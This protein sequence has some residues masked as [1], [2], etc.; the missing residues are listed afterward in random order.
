MRITLLQYTPDPEKLIEYSARVCYLSHEKITPTSH[1]KFLPGLLKNGHL[2][3]FEHASASFFIEGISRAC[4]HQ[5]V[6]HRLASFSQQSQRYVEES[7]FAYVT[8]PEIA[9][10]PESKKIYE[11]T[12]SSIRQA[13]Q[14]LVALGIKRED[15]RFLLP[16]A[17]E[18]TLSMSANF[19][20]WL[21][22][23]DMRVSPHAQWEI[24]ELLT[25]IWKELYA[26]APVV[27]G[28]TYFENWSKDY[29]YKRE[30]FSRHIQA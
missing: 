1:E 4:S 12:M 28:L 14:K 2:S 18:T 22:V 24:R 3:V 19:R 30:V 27:F 10:S 16:N 26:I 23:I 7:G 6:R 15:A 9:S 8:P 29:E 11:E 20:E 13:Y 5:L 21:H 17:T 25:L